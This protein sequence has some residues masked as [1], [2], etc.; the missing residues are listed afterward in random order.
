MKKLISI[1]LCVVLMLSLTS[2]SLLEEKFPNIFGVE[3]S[4]DSNANLKDDTNDDSTENP[5]ETPEDDST[6]KPIEKPEEPIVNNELEFYTLVYE[7]QKLI[8]DYADDIYSCWYDYIYEDKY[9]SIDHAVLTAYL[10]NLTNISTI[11][12]NNEVIKSL[13]KTVRDG[14]LADETKAVMQAYNAYYSHIMEV[15]GSFKTFSADKETL[16]KNLANALKN[17][18]FEL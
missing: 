12:A 16:K 13:Y 10:L 18:E 11:E 2:C 5:A 1:L 17:L 14:K 3:S 9:D 4:D 6:E 7:T 15:S 8:D